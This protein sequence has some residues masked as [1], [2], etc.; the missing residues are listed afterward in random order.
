MLMKLNTLS[1]FNVLFC[2]IFLNVNILKAQEICGDG[3]DNDNDGYIDCYD[4]ACFGDASCDDDFIFQNGGCSVIDTCNYQLHLE[5]ASDEVLYSVDPRSV[6]M[7]GDVDNDGQTEVVVVSCMNGGNIFIFNGANGALKYQVAHPAV[8]N[9]KYGAFADING[10]GYAEI[11]ATAANEEIY[12]YEFNGFNYVQRSVSNVSYQTAIGCNTTGVPFI[13]DMNGDGNAEVIV[14]GSIYDANTLDLITNAPDLSYYPAIVDIFPSVPGLEYASGQGVYSY[15][16]VNGNWTQLTD[17]AGSINS[18]RNAVAS[19]DFDLDGDLDLIIRWNQ[20]L[21][22]KDGQTNVDIAS[23]IN[24]VGNVCSTPVVTDLEGDGEVE[25][26][27]NKSDRMICIE[28]N[29]GVLAIRWERTIEDNSGYI[30]PSVFDFDGDGKKE[31][32]IHDQD[33]INIL[34]INGNS[35]S[36]Y[37][38]GTFTHVD[39]PVIADVDNDNEAEIVTICGP[40][41]F[42]DNFCSG[43]HVEVLAPNCGTWVNARN[44]WNQH[45]YFVTN[46]NQDLTIPTNQQGHHLEFPAGSGLH[47]LNHYGAQV[48]FVNGSAPNPGSVVIGSLVPDATVTIDTV[49]TGI[50]CPEITI[51]ITIENLGSDTLP[52]WT[53]IS[54]YIGDPTTGTPDHIITTLISVEVAPGESVQLNGTIDGTGGDFSIFAIINGPGHSLNPIDFNNF[55]VSSILECDYFNN[56]D[57]FDFVFDMEEICGD[58]HDNDCNGFD[59]LTDTA[60][61]NKIPVARNDTVFI[62]EDTF[63]VVIDVQQNDTDRDE[64]DTLTTTIIGGPFNGTATVVGEAVTVSPVVTFSPVAGDQI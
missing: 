21:W 37:F 10:D 4:S 23:S 38:C 42:G 61:A 41:G 6:P 39:M 59:D 27:I 20:E 57:G 3:I 63:D 13:T 60:C 24:N 16:F 35:I 32:V 31:I 28:N 2:L 19:A 17:F 58:G 26:L 48:N 8:R 15:D 7:V 50:V 54:F 34:D 49:I 33:S 43:G 47:A 62:P 18:S 25:I 40:G 44:I 52:D 46:I 36:N 29:G 53:Q 56:M 45:R 5:W 1:F 14:Y 64:D 55:P 51:Y 30:V 22:V 11:F 9:H 12:S